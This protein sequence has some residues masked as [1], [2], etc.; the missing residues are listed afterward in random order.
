M[1]VRFLLTDIYNGC[2]NVPYFKNY[3]SGA[4]NFIQ[5]F[6][7]IFLCST[8]L[9]TKQQKWGISRP[10]LKISMENKVVEEARTFLQIG[11]KFLC[12]MYF[13]GILCIKYCKKIG[14][15]WMDQS[16][17]ILCFQFYSWPPT[18]N[19]RRSTK[20]RWNWPCQKFGK[21]EQFNHYVHLFARQHYTK[22]TH[23][24]VANGL[25][26]KCQPHPRP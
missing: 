2:E 7:D 14:W 17:K 3:Y 19:S 5:S 4:F 21:W 26:R 13:C 12:A 1:S 20:S 22:H 18:F 6:Y 10:N 15:N 16:S 25:I 23:F 11:V 8:V 9:K 24:I